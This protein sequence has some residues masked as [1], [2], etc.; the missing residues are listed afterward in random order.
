MLRYR[1]WFYIWRQHSNVHCVCRPFLDML[2]VISWKSRLQWMAK[3]GDI[4]KPEFT[5]FMI[6]WNVLVIKDCNSVVFWDIDLN[7]FVHAYL[8]SVYLECILRNEINCRSPPRKKNLTIKLVENH[9]FDTDFS[10]EYD[11]RLWFFF[12]RPFLTLE[13]NIPRKFQLHWMDRRWKIQKAGQRLT[14]GQSEM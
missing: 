9:K 1:Q 3:S 10:C 6:C 13:R 14:D 8:S 12:L 5:D 7:F 11:T 4:Q 2:K